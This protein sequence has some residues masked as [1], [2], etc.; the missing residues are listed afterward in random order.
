MRFIFVKAVSYQTLFREC[1]IQIHSTADPGQALSIML[2]FLGREFKCDRCDIYELRESNWL[3]HTC[4][5]NKTSPSETCSPLKIRYHTEIRTWYEAFY[6]GD[7][8]VISDMKAFAG[9]APDLYGYFN[10]KYAGIMILF[11]LICRSKLTGF[12]RFDSPRAGIKNVLELCK[13]LSYFICSMLERRDL[14]DHLQYL[15]Y[16]DQLTGALNRYALYEYVK[17]GKLD[18]HPL[19][20]VY[21]DIIGLK[22]VNDL[23]GHTN[24][25]QVIV[26]TYQALTCVFGADQVYRMGG[27]EFLALCVRLSKKQFEE[28]AALFSRE[29]VS[30]NCSLSIGTAWEEDGKC[31]F[32]DLMKLADQ[33]MYESK[34]EFYEQTDPSSGQLRRIQRQNWHE[35][36][37]PSA[38]GEKSFEVFIRNYHFDVEAFFHSMSV[39]GAPLYLYCGDMQKNIFFIS[40]NLREDFN[41][42][43][44]LVYDFITLL[45]QRI[46]EADRQ[47]YMDDM[48]DMLE[49]KKTIHNIRCRIHNKNGETVWMHC[50]GVLKW[51]EAMTKPVFFSGSM[52][53]ELEMDPTTGMLNLS[54]GFDKIA[55]LCRSHAKLLILCFSLR[56]FFEINKMLGHDIGDSILF[57]IG[58]RIKEEF[59]DDFLTIRMDGL[60]FMVVSEKISDPTEPV[61]KIHQIVRDIYNR[62]GAHIL[63]PCVVGVLRSP[64]DGLTA[65]DLVENATIVLHVAKTTPEVQYLE[66]S[67]EISRRYEDRTDISMSL[68]AS[69]NHMFEG[70]RITIQPQVIAKTGQIF[71]GE[72]LLR[73]KYQDQNVPPAKFIPVLEQTGLIVPVGKWIII[74]SLRACREIL[75]IMPEFRLSVNISYLQIVDQSFITFLQKALSAY[76]IPGGSLVIELTETHS[77]TMPDHL[78]YFIGECRKMGISFALDDFGSAY[79]SLRLLLQ[80]PAELI[81]LDRTL[82]QEITESRDKMNFIMSIIYACH[83]FGKRVCVEGV[84]TREELEIIRRTECDFIQGFYFYKPLELENFYRVLQVSHTSDPQQHRRL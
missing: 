81:K 22:N 60:R 4:N 2:S 23:L 31:S 41:F 72:V 34:R 18:G 19:G 5:W 53:R 40:D 64:R 54:Y 79:S 42:S 13:I 38:E 10:P 78:K 35:S 57:E 61:G 56:S 75:K 28:Q 65:H 49:N 21:C 74:Q 15:S 63:Y 67:P 36:L 12:L 50:H 17:S 84:E 9:I 80:Y 47:A 32:N 73:W 11:P 26:R 46:Y 55:S 37:A 45:E 48:R 58:V 27:D 59:G 66:F 43:G 69:I 44:N 1:L 7:P 51:D 6:H 29:A 71:G 24:G 62:Y 83:K 8:I 33:K 16:H 68:N 30:Q 76:G 25:D 52:S 14:T 77:D 70:F 82:M 3:H 20:I 39:N